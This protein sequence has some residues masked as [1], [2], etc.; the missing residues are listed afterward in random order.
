[1]VCSQITL[2]YARTCSH[3]S[4][5]PHRVCHP[6]WENVFIVVCP[7]F[8]IWPPTECEREREREQLS[9][10]REGERERIAGSREWRAGCRC[11]GKGRVEGRESPEVEVEK[12]IARGRP[13]GCR[14]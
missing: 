13:L 14:A 2:S 12:K 3:G 11:A 10:E 9:L 5:T 7:A 8:C 4:S 6:A 1:M